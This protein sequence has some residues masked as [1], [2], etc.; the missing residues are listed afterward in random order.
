ME[1]RSKNVEVG[2][3]AI[4]VAHC[5]LFELD[6]VDH[7]RALGLGFL[8]GG[9]LVF[10]VGIAVPGC[11]A[12]QFLGAGIAEDQHQALAVWRPF[13]GVNVLDGIRNLLGLAA[14]TIQEVELGLAVLVGVAAIRI[15]ALGEE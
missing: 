11:G 12:F 6:A 10:I 14:E 4:E 1:A 5:V 15:I 7:P 8:A 2:A 13:V 9:L 3:A